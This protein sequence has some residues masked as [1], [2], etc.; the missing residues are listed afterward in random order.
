MKITVAL[1]GGETKEFESSK[2]RFIRYERKKGYTE[3]VLRDFMLNGLFSEEQ[4]NQMINENN[5]KIS[6]EI[7]GNIIVDNKIASSIVR[8]FKL[9]TLESQEDAEEFTFI[10]E[11]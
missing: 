4:I 9:G 8:R 5:T 11:G 3:I 2:Y 10:L 1:N 6:L 7:K